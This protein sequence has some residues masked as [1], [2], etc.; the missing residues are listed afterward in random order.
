[1]IRALGRPACS[2]GLL[3]RRV[4]TPRV[5][6]REQVAPLSLTLAPTQLATEVVRSLNAEDLDGFRRAVAPQVLL[7]G[8]GA[9]ASTVSAD[10]LYAR[11][12]TLKPRQTLCAGR[13]RPS[14]SGARVDLEIAWPTGSGVAASSLGRLELAVSGGRVTGLA[15]ALDTDPVLEQAAAALAAH[16]YR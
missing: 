1:M 8:G 7:T 11:L 13:V 16:A 15:L 2:L 4:A 3:G 6:T 5:A 12:T 9:P 14:G 10:D